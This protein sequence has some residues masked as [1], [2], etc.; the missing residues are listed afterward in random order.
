MRRELV[1]S[2]VVHRS[3]A[4]RDCKRCIYIYISV[5]RNKTYATTGKRET[6]PSEG[7]RRKRNSNK[8]TK[9][10]L[11]RETGTDRESDAAMA[12]SHSNSKR[13][14]WPGSGLEVAW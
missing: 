7:K 2:F 12:Q 13:G 3:I 6:E 8:D 5:I 1:Y 10:E 14:E 11:E 9:P 4:I